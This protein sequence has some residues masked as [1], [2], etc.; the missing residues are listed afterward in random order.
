MN[1]TNRRP[2]RDC[3]QLIVK[4][5]FF[6]FRKSANKSPQMAGT[7]RGLFSESFHATQTPIQVVYFIVRMRIY[8]NELHSG[9]GRTASWKRLNLAWSWLQSVNWGGSRIVD[10][11]HWTRRWRRFWH[12]RGQTSADYQGAVKK[13]LQI[14]NDSVVHLRLTIS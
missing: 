7:K 14:A 8:R 13:Y 3:K 10:N 5:S 1:N 6:F 4:G 9:M 2:Q 12:P 11:G